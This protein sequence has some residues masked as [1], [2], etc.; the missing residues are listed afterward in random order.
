M[1]RNSV[2]ATVRDVNQDNQ[3]RQSEWGQVGGRWS[4]AGGAPGS[5]APPTELAKQAEQS[6]AVV[7]RNW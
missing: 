1:S 7:Q 4:D 5:I 6:G 2:L 3:V